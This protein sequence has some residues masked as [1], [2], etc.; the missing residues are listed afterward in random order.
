MT[1]ESF[2]NY[3]FITVLPFALAFFVA[4][5]C[6]ATLKTA[7]R[8]RHLGHSVGTL[9]AALCLIGSLLGVGFGL[10]GE[11][12]HTSSVV[13]ALLVMVVVSASFSSLLTLLSKQG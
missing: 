7:G 5:F 6:Y 12:L 1:L 2:T 8:E 10:M 9:N 13:Q 11:T 4:L 3:H